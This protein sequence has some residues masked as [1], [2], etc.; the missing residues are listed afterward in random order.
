MLGRLR[1]SVD[2]CVTEYA[3]LG[4]YIF[5]ERQGFPEEEMF[6][7]SRLEFAIKRVIKKKLGDDQ[8]NASLLDPLG[9]DC[10][11]TYVQ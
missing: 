3:A 1:M 4:E 6:D 11:K 8:E 9:E 10:C 2:D 5:G 7:A